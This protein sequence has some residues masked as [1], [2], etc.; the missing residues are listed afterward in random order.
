MHTERADAPV[1][2][3]LRPLLWRLPLV[4]FFLLGGICL[5]YLDTRLVTEYRNGAIAQAGQLDALLESAIAERVT[6]LR[7]V[8]RLV[9]EASSPR[10]RDARFRALADEV[11]TAAPDIPAIY[12]L[13]AAGTVEDVQPRGAAGD[14]LLAQNHLLLAPLADA[15]V[16]AQRTREA[17]ISG[18]IPIRPDTLGVMLYE[19]VITR[20]R[21]TGHIG[22]A[23]AY[24]ALL[25]QALAGGTRGRFAYRVRDSAGTVLGVSSA[26]PRTTSTTVPRTITLPGGLTWELDVAVEPFQPLLARI[27]L[28]GVGVIMLALVLLL[29]VREDMRNERLAMHSFNLELLSRNLLDA[30]VKLEERAQQVTEANRA[31]SRFLAN[32]SHELRTPLNAIVGY[33]SLAVSGLYG[34][35]AP[36][37]RTAL[38]RTGAA[39]RHLLGV[40][41]DVLDLSKIEVGRMEV[42]ARPVDIERL[43][44]DVVSVVEPVADAKGVRVDLVIARDVPAV[45]T[46]PLHL[47]QIVMNLTSNAIKFT[48]HGSVTLVAKAD[49]PPG[50]GAGATGGGLRVE[51]EDTGIGIEPA[52]LERIFDE[53]EQVRPGG[54]G[55]SLTRGTGLGLAISR[56]LARLLGGD[57][58]AHST[59]GAGSRFTVTVPLRPPPTVDLGGLRSEAREVE[60][61]PAVVRDGAPNAPRPAE[62]EGTRGADPARPRP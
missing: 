13:D 30:N 4:L 34:E 41:N 28:W 38:D 40:V 12:R 60:V 11:L 50:G 42:D 45:T 27:V 22:A 3:H 32:V 37:L 44:E 9:G 24:G 54:R 16:R 15:I 33:N 48:E 36:P 25:R 55:D 2:S 61:G 18:L 59:V 57:V 49:E 19:P 56:K 7:S 43:L 31:K 47:R 29:V 62:G 39:A 52:D 21:I 17:T 5:W 6:L 58:T 26:F 51:I 1:R 53:F 46:D 23:V 35:L 8:S 14:E 20:G 10:E